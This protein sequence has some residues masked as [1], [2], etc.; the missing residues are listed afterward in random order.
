MGLTDISWAT[1]LV[2]WSQCL[3]PAHLL[4]RPVRVQK[5]Q[6]W[7]GYSQVDRVGREVFCSCICSEFTY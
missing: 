6:R 4:Q 2:Q 7:L 3:M 1:F 5:E